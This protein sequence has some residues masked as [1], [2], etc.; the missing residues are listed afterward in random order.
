MLKTI[1][2]YRKALIAALLGLV[3]TGCGGQ[4][5]LS[6]EFSPPAV[7]VKPTPHEP[8]ATNPDNHTSPNNTSNDEWSDGNWGDL[9]WT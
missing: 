6:E 5:E 3:V 4:N 8:P 9:T 7:L 1:N 2:K